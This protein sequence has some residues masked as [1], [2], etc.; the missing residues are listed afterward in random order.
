VATNG[1]GTTT[2]Q[3]LTFTTGQTVAILSAST[4]VSTKGGVLKLKI[5]CRGLTSGRCSGPITVTS[6]VT[7]RGGRPVAVSARV[8]P[9]RIRTLVIVAAGRYSVP[10][11]ATR[12]ITLKLNRTGRSLLKRFH[13]LPATL[14][15]SGAKPPT[16]R[17]VFTAPKPKHKKHHRS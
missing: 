3:E 5:A 9:R 6:H 1:D 7:K 10:A 17:I 12:T 2:S 16:R 11:G 13:R 14:T 8:K 15:V 4:R